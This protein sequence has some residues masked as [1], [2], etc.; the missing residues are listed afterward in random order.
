MLET[1]RVL[2]GLTVYIYMKIEANLLKS[3]ACK[4]LDIHV[5]LFNRLLNNVKRCKFIQPIF[6]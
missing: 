4:T 1:K 2:F 3:V 5:P 6:L